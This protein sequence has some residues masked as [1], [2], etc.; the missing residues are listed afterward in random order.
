M[1]FKNRRYPEGNTLLRNLEKNYPVV[2]HGE[3][4]YLY[5]LNGKKYFDGSGGALV[6]SLG[7]GLTELVDSV[8]SQMKRV[9]Y[10][11][12]HHFTSAA[13]EEFSTRL[14]QISPLGDRA[15]A[16][17][18]GSG[19]E[20]IESAFKFIR[21]LWVERGEPD[22]SV[23]IARSPGYHGNTLFALSA[24]ARPYYRKFFGPMLSHVEMVE[25]PYTYR[26]SHGDYE[27][28][29]PDYFAD[30][31]ENKIKSLGAKTIAGFIC[32]PVSGSSTGAS[33]PPKNYFR[34][35]QQVCQKYQIPIIADEVM[36]GSGRTGK[37]FASD[38]F[39]L[40]PDVIVLG[41]GINAGLMP[42]S[43]VIVR[44]EHVNEMKKAS[45]GFMHAQTY[46]H[47]PALAATG[48]AVLDYFEK[49][50]V[51]DNSRKI[52]EYLKNSLNQRFGGHPNVGFVSGLGLMIGIEFVKDKSTKKPFDRSQKVAENFATY[53]FE[54]GLLVWTNTGHA[55][56]I[57]G[58][59]IM[60]GPPLNINKSHVDDL[61]ERL[62]TSLD[63]FKN[64]P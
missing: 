6:T 35:I 4:P 33:V 19:S 7:H 40:K 58:D 50:A 60:L 37:F 30:Q 28:E 39:D 23:F 22:R 2:S 24:S 27:V 64:L 46:M 21:Q 54:K 8:A 20:A 36:C 61:V 49:N 9:A 53:A 51:V 63:F 3:G 62:M 1:Q 29:G 18:L 41:K 16:G 56:G 59:L 43:A 31:L 32:E 38:H 25:T 42:M 12:G 14:A 52:G 44:G 45:G 55:D 34:E 15:R 13:M 5:D 57:N 10:V 26:Y 48:L 17:L 47:T 11:N